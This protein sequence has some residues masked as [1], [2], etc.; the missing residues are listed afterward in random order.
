M[1]S[2][3]DHIMEKSRRARF[4]VDYIY[5][6]PDGANHRTQVSSTNVQLPYLAKS[7]TAVLSWL[8]KRHRGAEITIIGLEW[9]DI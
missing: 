8:R 4:R 7:E 5:A 1:E 2:F 3:I 9:S 6:K